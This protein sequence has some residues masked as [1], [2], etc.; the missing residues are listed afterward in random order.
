MLLLDTVRQTFEL[1]L[2]LEALRSKG[3]LKVTRLLDVLD[4]EEG[5]L[6]L[7]LDEELVESHGLPYNL[8]RLA[9]FFWRFV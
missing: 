2:D 9:R 7:G 6:L 1:D 4:L 5:V 3:S 8:R